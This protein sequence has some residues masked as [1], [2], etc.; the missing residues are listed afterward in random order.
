MCF[1]C[2]VQLTLQALP[3]LPPGASG[4]LLVKVYLRTL[5]ILVKTRLKA[6]M[7]KYMQFTVKRYHQAMFDCGTNVV[8]L[9]VG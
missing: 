9:R 6:I 1:V 5:K 7:Q 8:E 4:H 3:G 2:V